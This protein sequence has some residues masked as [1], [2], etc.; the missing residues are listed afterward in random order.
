MSEKGHSVLLTLPGHDGVSVF[1]DRR[2]TRNDRRCGSQSQL[3]TSAGLRGVTA[4]LPVLLCP[5]VRQQTLDVCERP[6]EDNGAGG[7]ERIHSFI[8]PHMK[9]YRAGPHAH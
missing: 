6:A 9:N 2:S 3:M 5:S 1:W 8:H 4:M 7:H